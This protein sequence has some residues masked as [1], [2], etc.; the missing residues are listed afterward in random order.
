MSLTFLFFNVHDSYLYIST[1]IAVFI[2]WFNLL[3]YLQRFNRGGIY[4]VMFLEILS[5]LIKVIFL[6]SVLIIAFGL[7]FYIL[8]A[9]FDMLRSGKG[10]SR[11]LLSMIRIVTMMLGEVDFIGTF[12]QPVLFKSIVDED[13]SAVQ[14]ERYQLFISLLFLVIFI[15]LMPILLMN[16]LI[17]LAVGDIDTVRKNAQLKRLTMQVD[18]HTDLERKLPQKFIQMTDKKEIYEYPNRCCGSSFF[19]SF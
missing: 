2:A 15:I 5:T 7:S 10:F 19:V 9:K 11:P 4:V 14:I 6:F 18:L 8:F 17:G 13:N 3:F 12:L 1:S 16:L